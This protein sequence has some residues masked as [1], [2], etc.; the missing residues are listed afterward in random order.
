MSRWSRRLECLT[1]IAIVTLIGV[2]TLGLFGGGL[3]FYWD[4]WSHIWWSQMAGVAGILEAC[5]ND[6]PILGILVSVLYLLV[7]WKPFTLHILSLLVSIWGA[8]AFKGI[9]NKVWPE[10]RLEALAAAL[11]F[12]VYPGFSLHPVSLITLTL[13]AGLSLQITSIYLYVQ[14]LTSHRGKTAWGLWAGTILLALLAWSI[15]ESSFFVE[16]FRYGLVLLWGVFHH[17]LKTVHIIKWTFSRLWPWLVTTA[18]YLLYRVYYSSSSRDVGNALESTGLRDFGRPFLDWVD[19]TLYAWV[20]PPLAKAMANQSFILLLS[21]GVAAIA[22]TSWVLYA[23]SWDR[24]RVATSQAQG[25]GGPWELLWPGIILATLVAGIGLSSWRTGLCLRQP[26]PQILVFIPLVAGLI[27]A[28]Q[29][30]RGHTISGASAENWPWQWLALGGVCS[31]LGLVMLGLVNKH[32]VLDNFRDRFTIPA[33][34]GISVFWV[35]AIGLLANKALRVFLIATLITLAVVFH[36]G[37]GNLFREGW[38]YQRSLA[39]Q[40]WE[41]APSLEPGTVLVLDAGG[42]P[43]KLKYY[44]LIGL[45]SAVYSHTNIEQAV[46]AAVLGDFKDAQISRSVIAGVQTTHGSRTI[47]FPVDFRKSLLLVMPTKESCLH[48]VDPKSPSLPPGAS[49]LAKE[50]VRYSNPEVIGDIRGPLPAVSMFGHQPPCDWCTIYQRA[51]LAKQFNHWQEVIDLYD[52]AQKMGLGPGNASEL[53]PFLEGFLRLGKHDNA[54]RIS[55]I[56]FANERAGLEAQRLLDQYLPR[57]IQ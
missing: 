8:L 7:G 39:W 53:L 23:W 36:I 13:L 42:M 20:F 40:L 50:L 5:A 17:K 12:L 6:R 32:V 25:S 51:E 2:L 24:R 37:N 45:V 4:E 10:L 41:R 9:L 3:G 15:Y 54:Q 19:S 48:V 44:N 16:P 22:V 34:M 28:W 21:L 1:S 14:I 56:I 31:L 55:N 18:T 29:K 52:Q 47:K 49:G 35:G 43:N 26:L 11:L 46:G 33:M 27:S 38:K 57:S 30:G